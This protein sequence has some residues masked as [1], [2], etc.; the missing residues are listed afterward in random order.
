MNRRRA[1]IVVAVATAASVVASAAALLSPGDDLPQAPKA[2]K[3]PKLSAQL[4]AVVEAERSGRGLAVARA[5]GLHVERGRVR[6]VVETR[7]PRAAARRAVLAVGGVL[8]AAHADLVQA[9]VAPGKLVALSK[10][11]SVVYVRVPR[12]S[13]PG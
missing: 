6:V 1:S 12:T 2:T 3:H 5:S 7:G 4:V 13:L 8:E 11:P 10:E 9:L